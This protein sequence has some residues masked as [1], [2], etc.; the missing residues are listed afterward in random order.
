[1]EVY[2]LFR[3]FTKHFIV[4]FPLQWEYQWRNKGTYGHPGG[5][6]HAGLHGIGTYLCVVWFSIP[7]AIVFAVFDSVVHYHIDWA[8]MNL[9]SGLTTVDHKFWIWLGFDQMLHYLTYILIIGM[10]V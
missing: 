1:M 4:D 5:L 10:I 9:S 2:L 6:I 8:K 7:V 3:L